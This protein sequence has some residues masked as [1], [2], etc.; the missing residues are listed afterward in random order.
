MNTMTLM[1]LAGGATG[2]GLALAVFGFRPARPALAEALDSLSRPPAPALPRSARIDIV[3]ARP[4]VA[5]GFPRQKTLRDLAILDRD[6]AEY[7]AQ[8][9]TVGFAGA[10]ILG[11]LPVLWGAGGQ[12]PVWLAILGGLLAMQVMAS[13]VRTAAAERRDEMRET[14]S[15]ILDLVGG[16]LA[17]G[18]GIDQALGDTL[19]EMS[20]WAALRVRRELAAAAQTRGRDRIRTPAALKQLADQIGVDELAELATAVEHAATGAPVAENIAILAHTISERLTSDMERQANARSAQL[21]IPIMLYGV[22]YLIFLLFAALTSI[23][24]GLSG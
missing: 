1:L 2:L 18:A 11:M 9:I 20:G 10:V 8:Q 24:S 12:L 22:G 17:G 5:R 4:L 14:L 15:V 7:L 23:R 13:R 3:L 6:P 19:A 21:A 16:S